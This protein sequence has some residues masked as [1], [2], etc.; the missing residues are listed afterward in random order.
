MLKNI[1][2][3]FREAGFSCIYAVSGNVEYSKEK[4]GGIE[5]IDRDDY[6]AI[7]DVVRRADFIA[8]GGGGLFQDHN[9]LETAGLFETPKMGVHSYINVPL[10]AH[11]YKKPIAYLFQGVGPLFSED[12]RNFTSYAYSLSNYIS[13]RDRDSM[14]LLE[15]IGIREVVLSADPGFLY[16]VENIRSLDHKPKI[17][18]CLRQWVDKSVEELIVAAFKDFLDM[19]PED[20][21]FYFISFQDHDEGNTDSAIFQRIKSGLKRP[22]SLALIRSKNYPLEDME[23]TIAG[24]DFLVGMRL[25]SIILAMKYGIPFIA[26][27]Y[28]NKVDHLLTET[29][30]GDLS[31]G[32]NDISGEKIRD[33][34]RS[35]ISQPCEIK[36]RIE[37]GISIIEQRLQQGTDT[38]RDF[39]TDISEIRSIPLVAERPVEKSLCPRNGSATRHIRKG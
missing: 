7:A 22:E 6:H 35:L 19:A 30:L 25:H 32:I 36:K 29:G 14:R 15:E 33:K 16:P 31:V 11:I 17:G 20:N 2:R 34:F 37:K 23:K 9:R 10:I 13:V 8:L 38:M 1:A 26:I 4:H 3:M 28:W 18:I 27:P 5:F 39:L 21:D 24:L 12:S